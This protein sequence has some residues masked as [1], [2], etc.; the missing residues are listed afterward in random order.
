MPVHDAYARLTPYELLQ[1]DAEFPSRHFAAIRD[2]AVETGADLTNPAAFVMTAAVRSALAELQPDDPESPSAGREAGAAYDHGHALFFAFHMWRAGREL[3]LLSRP[4][5]AR[6]TS[7][8]SEAPTPAPNPA[9]GWERSL[10]GRAG[11]V[12]FPQHLVWTSAGD[13]SPPESIDGF[14]WTAGSGSVLHLAAVSGMHP[15]RPGYS[16]LAI[17]PQPLA[18]LSEWA[19]GPAREGDRDFSTS[20]PGGEID[21]LVEIRTPAE[22]LKLA[23]RA[24]GTIVACDSTSHDQPLPKIDPPPRHED[25]ST[26]P[27]SGPVPSSLPYTV[28]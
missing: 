17:A 1:P 16:F 3:L 28:V 27:G 7:T 25:P 22:L 5:V 15:A 9:A 12:Q 4:T 10:E 24:L 19:A 2:E 14:F 8:E 18:T 13:D 26:A 21:G 20:L 6:L 11:Y 23:S